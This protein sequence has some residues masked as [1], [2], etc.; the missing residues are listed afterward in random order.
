MQR[1][2]KWKTTK[3][4]LKIDDFVIIKEDFLPPTEWKM[5]RIVGLHAGKDGHVRVAEIR[6]ANGNITRPLVKI[7][8]LP[9]VTMPQ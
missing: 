3:E 1:R 6:T 9:F 5:G 8:L 2:Y 4:N 7:C